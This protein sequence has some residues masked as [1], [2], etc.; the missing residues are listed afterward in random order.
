MRNFSVSNVLHIPTARCNLVS[1]SRLERKGVNTQTGKGKITDFNAA[2][3]PFTTGS[4]VKDLYK[5]DVET[6]TPD[7]EAQP[8][9]DLIATMMPSVDLLFGPG[10]KN[11]ETQKEGFTIV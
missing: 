8:S 4:I 11:A 7:E 1:G 9:L 2:N 6:V 3:I 5:M 10:A